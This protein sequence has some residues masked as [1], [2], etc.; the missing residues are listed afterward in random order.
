M[1]VYLTYHMG[2]GYFLMP[3]HSIIIMALKLIFYFGMTPFVTNLTKDDMVVALEL[4][5]LVFNH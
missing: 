2:T 1:F 4:C 3:L 5:M